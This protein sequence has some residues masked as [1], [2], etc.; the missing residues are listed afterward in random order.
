[1][2]PAA[3]TIVNTGNL[4]GVTQTMTIH[5]DAMAHIMSVLTNLYSDPIMAVIREYST[6]ALDAH[7][8]AGLAK[9]IHV[10]LPSVLKPTLSIED[11]GVGMS[12]DQILSLYSSYGAST[13]RGTNEQTGMLGLG[14]KSALAYSAQFTIRSRK[15]GVETSALI[16]LNDAGEGEIKITDTRSCTG[17]GT[18]IEIPVA[19]KDATEFVKKA[20]SLFAYWPKG[21]VDL[22]GGTHK[23]GT[24]N[25]DWIWIADNIALTPRDVDDSGYYSRFADGKVVVVQGGVPY[26]VDSDKV[27][28]EVKGLIRTLPLNIHSVVL[29]API[30]TVQFTPSREDLYYTNNTNATLES[31]IEAYALRIG[32]WITDRIATAASKRD[33]MEAFEKF[34]DL[35]PSGTS[36]VYKGETVP[37]SVDCTCTATN[38]AKRSNVTNYRTLPSL[39]QMDKY[40]L[41]IYGCPDSATDARGSYAIRLAAAGKLTGS[42]SLSEAWY[43]NRASQKD[44]LMIRGDLPEGWDWYGITA[45]SYDSIKPSGGRKAKGSTSQADLDYLD[46]KWKVVG[47]YG[48]TEKCDPTDDKV[49]YVEAAY[50][51]EMRDHPSD[52]TVFMVPANQ[53][54][55][56]A[57]AFPLAR[58]REQVR[59]DAIKAA[60]IVLD[61]AASTYMARGVFAYFDRP[62]RA[63]LDTKKV[64]DKDLATVLEWKIKEPASVKQINKINSDYSWLKVAANVTTAPTP[65]LDRVS[66][67]YGFLN[68]VSCEKAEMLDLVNALYTYKYLGGT[69]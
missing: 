59:Q 3:S 15:G 58:T 66:K 35:L 19:G 40:D 25:K 64:L 60:K 41:V 62:G 63:Y 6:N 24:S 51:W 11:F 27:S 68:A 32:A 7:R 17:T 5:R 61:E 10:G 67:R 12:T 4:G 49:V 47:Q 16:F 69:P 22:R 13:K 42:Y 38:T 45:V 8:E 1:M 48:V 28:P 55:R 14:S 20:E 31:L 21:D 52:W 50:Q 65:T 44:I 54:A 2:K 46:R 57:K 29:V 36:C 23:P 37:A 53:H 34:S 30:G 39:A 56:F 9:P 43:G 33:A 26:T 18:R